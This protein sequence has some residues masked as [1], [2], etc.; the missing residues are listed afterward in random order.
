[1]KMETEMEVE[2]EEPCGPVDASHK[3][4]CLDLE[5]ATQCITL[6]LQH[7]V[8]KNQELRMLICRL[9]E[10]EAETGRSLTEQVESNK[11]LK[12]KIDELQHLGEKD[13]SLTQANQT[14]SFLKNEL[15]E[16]L[17]QLHNQRS[18]R[19]MQVVL[20]KLQGWERH[21]EVRHAQLNS[22]LQ[23]TAGEESLDWSEVVA[24]NLLVS[25]IKEENAV[26]GYEE[27]S[28]FEGADHKA[29]QSSS[30]K[31]KLTQTSLVSSEGLVAPATD[32]DDYEDDGDTVVF[33]DDD[34][35]E[36]Y[37]DDGDTDD[38]DDDEEYTDYSR[39]VKTR[40]RGK[41]RI[42]QT[43]TSS[44]AIQAYL[45]QDPAMDLAAPPPVRKRRPIT[46]IVWH[47]F[48][49]SSADP[50]K[51]ICKLCKA[52]IGRGRDKRKLSTTPMHNHL[53]CKHSA[54]P[55]TPPAQGHTPP[56]DL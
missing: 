45:L 40:K 36:D 28:R 7:E 1:M 41:S 29:E 51:A 22:P 55:K 6:A 12:L 17:Q 39:A 46:S 9:E 14:V 47:H 49:V 21:L 37:E 20:E 2:V 11:Q 52:I 38:D 56:T 23:P 42:D 8:V 32:D 16:L 48:T 30:S 5:K 15:R 31:P 13:H 33:D 19:V 4:V 43:R 10:K 34:D 50:T 54:L 27:C 24:P 18:N 26:P 35:D 53:Q 3:Q 25:G 44:G